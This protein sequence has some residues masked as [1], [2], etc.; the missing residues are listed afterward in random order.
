MRPSPV[1]RLRLFLLTVGWAAVF[2]GSSRYLALALPRSVARELSL[3]AYLAVVHVLTLLLALA[4]ARAFVG[5]PDRVLGAIPPPVTAVA[6]TLALTPLVFTASTSIAFLIARP[7]LI[8]ELLRG[9]TELAQKNTGE[10]GRE[11]TREPALV[12]VLWGAVVSPVSEEL[13]FRGALYSLVES[14]VPPAVV[15]RVTRSALPVGV[16]AVAFGL[17]HWDMPGGLGIVRLVS[18]LGLGLACG[19]A[20]AATGSVVAAILVHVPFNLLAIAT[21]RRWAVFPSFPQKWGVPILF[22]VA[23]ALGA[24]GA[25]ALRYALRPNR[26]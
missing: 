5:T 17:L 10:F 11:L 13:F 23:A 24:A 16:V 7:T 20:R 12:T 14:L 2:F 21:V 19:V 26:P 22:W 6:T 8:A 25:L 15:G 3:E 9:G 1:P 18:A 4:A